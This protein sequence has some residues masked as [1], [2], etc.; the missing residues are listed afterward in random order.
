MSESESYRIELLDTKSII[1]LDDMKPINQIIYS[2]IIIT[3]ICISF[4]T[5]KKYEEG[6]SLSLRSKEARVVNTWKVEKYYKNGEDKTADFF[7]DKINYIETFTE[8]GKWSLSY[9]DASDNELETDSGTWEFDKDSNKEK[10]D[11]NAGG[12]TW[13]ELTILKLKNKEFWF[14]YMDSGDK[15]EYHLIPSE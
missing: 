3:L 1:N 10:I 7:A 6:P 15:K 9:T 11:R 2:F 8:D 5:C 14:W 12:S 4:T 13:E